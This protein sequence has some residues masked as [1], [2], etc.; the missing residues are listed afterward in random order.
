MG[1]LR[2]GFWLL[3]VPESVQCQNL[4]SPSQEAQMNCFKTHIFHKQQYSFNKISGELPVT[5]ILQIFLTDL[6]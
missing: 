5:A 6:I 1:N 2:F 3:Y 4:K